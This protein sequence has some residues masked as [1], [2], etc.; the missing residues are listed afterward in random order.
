MRLL[1]STQIY[2]DVTPKAAAEGEEDMDMDDD[3]DYILELEANCDGSLLAASL[4]SLGVS[5]H[6]AATLAATSRLEGMHTSRIN[7]IEFLR[8]HP[9]ILVSSSDDKRLRMWDLRAAA[10]G[11]VVDMRCREEVMDVSVGHGDAL[12]ACAVGTSV[13]FYD[14]RN[15]SGTSSW[16]SAAAQ[17]G[18]YADAHTDTISQL[19]FH[20]CRD[21]EIATASEDGLIC[22]FNTRAA[23]GSE[24]IISIMNTECPVRRF[25]FFGQEQEGLYCLSTVETASFW[26]PVSA[27]RINAHA[28]LREDFDLDYLVDCFYSAASGEL[29]LLGGCHNGQGKVL[30]VTPAAVTQVGALKGGHGS[31]IRCVAGN[32]VGGGKFVTGGEDSRLCAWEAKATVRG[33][34]RERP[35]GKS[36]GKGKSDKGHHHSPY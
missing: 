4:S 29:L 36:K 27:Q 6:D 10:V 23:E 31:T 33:P 17:L 2:S 32:A 15:S 19:R 24:A 21:A 7:G 3:A 8:Q 11:P 34:E 12:L 20:P 35:G 28:S 13:L 18:E 26:H 25:G 14:V 16:A 9:H 5:I 1:G 22:T 30:S